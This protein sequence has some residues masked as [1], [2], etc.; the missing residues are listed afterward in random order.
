[1]SNTSGN[2]N[3]IIFKDGRYRDKT[4]GRFV[5][6]P[7]WP[8]GDS[9]P[10]HTSTSSNVPVTR[11]DNDDEQDLRHRNSPS[12]GSDED[13]FCVNQDDTKHSSPEGNMVFS[14]IVELPDDGNK[15]KR[16]DELKFDPIPYY[17]MSPKGEPTKRKSISQFSR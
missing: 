17:N 4:T 8:S 3:N 12:F 16:D 7:V 13:I 1:M 5:S 14:P 15:T 2:N 10:S 11:Q 9:I 6:A